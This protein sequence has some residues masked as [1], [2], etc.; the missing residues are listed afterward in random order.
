MLR[1]MIVRCT[2]DLCTNLQTLS[3]PVPQKALTDSEIRS[4]KGEPLVAG[5]GSEKARILSRIRN[6]LDAPAVSKIEEQ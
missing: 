6:M 5:N 2:E 4:P 1:I 3:R